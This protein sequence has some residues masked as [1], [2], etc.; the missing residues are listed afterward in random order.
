MK[1]VEK[2]FLGFQFDSTYYSKSEIENLL[3]ESVTEATKEIKKSGLEYVELDPQMGELKPSEGVTEGILRNIHDSIFCL[4]E[5][6]DNNANV[7]FELGN[8]Y[9]KEK[10]LIFLK[11]RESD[12]VAKVPSDIIGKYIWYYGGDGD[13]SLEKLRPR[14]TKH[15]KEYV[16]DWYNKKTETWIRKVWTIKGDRLIVVSGNLDDQYKVWPKDADALFESTL[17]LTNLYPGV[18]A[19]RIYSKDFTEKDYQNNDLFVVGGPDS[20]WVTADILED[21]DPSF[22]FYYNEIGEP[23]FFELC[24]KNTSNKYRRTYKGKKLKT[25]YG[26]FLKVPNPYDRE[27]NVLIISGIGDEGTFG[28]SKALPFDDGDFLFNYYSETFSKLSDKKIYCFITEALI[29]GSKI[30]GRVVEGTTF[31]LNEKTDHWEKL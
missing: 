5:I 18:K 15:L 8:A 16:I 2:V 29:Q 3:V 10:G 6:S 26:F 22:P 1:K 11:N 30:T 27:R 4:F 24:D 14:I 21:L 7:M 17:G 23:D 25:D 13:P 20:N 9:A 31:Y 19:K 28:C 12:S